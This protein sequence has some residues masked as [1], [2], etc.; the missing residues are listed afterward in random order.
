MFRRCFRCIN[1][2]LI[3]EKTYCAWLILLNCATRSLWSMLWLFK[4]VGI[5]VRRVA[6]I[7]NHIWLGMSNQRWLS[8]WKMVYGNIH[9]QMLWPMFLSLIL[10]ELSR[11]FRFAMNNLY[12][13]LNFLSCFMT[14]RSICHFLFLWKVNSNCSIH[15]SRFIIEE[16]VLWDFH[17]YWMLV[18]PCCFYIF[19]ILNKILRP[20]V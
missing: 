17:K 18:R 2:I 10:L 6:Y 3:Y 19:E 5:Y 15:T 1:K 9:S 4:V 7:Y 12:I 14:L 20:K 16:E 13:V 8:Y 11:L